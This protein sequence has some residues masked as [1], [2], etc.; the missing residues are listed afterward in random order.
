MGLLQGHLLG[1]YRQGSR[2]GV[3]AHLLDAAQCSRL[4]HAGVREVEAQALRQDDGPL[5]VYMVPQLLHSPCSTVKVQ[6]P[7]LIQSVQ[8]RVMAALDSEEVWRVQQL[9]AARS[10]CI[11]CYTTLRC[12]KQECMLLPVL[13]YTGLSSLHASP[14]PS[15]DQCLVPCWEEQVDR[16]AA[17][18]TGV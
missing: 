4:N 3:Y 18:A 7:C 12:P 16:Q 13:S 9:S 15:Q 5:L 14:A 11:V 10:R 17:A 2:D 6:M 8:L 1:M